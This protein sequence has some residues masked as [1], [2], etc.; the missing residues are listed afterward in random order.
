M[1]VKIVV[2]GNH[3]KASFG[4]WARPGHFSRTLAKGPDTATWIWNLHVDAHDFD[5][6]TGVVRQFQ[7]TCPY[8][9]LIQDY[10]P[11]ILVVIIF[12]HDLYSHGP[13]FMILLQSPIS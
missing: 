8:Q 5:S 10:R 3:V 9:Q 4:E 2:D 12:F 7:N 13:I 1:E 11:R 6:H